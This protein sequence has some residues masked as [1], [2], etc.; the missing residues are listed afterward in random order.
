MTSP[1]N[2]A[3]DVFAELL[4]ASR[5]LHLEASRSRRIDDMLIG[6]SVAASRRAGRSLIGLNSDGVNHHLRFEDL[7]TQT[8]V[9][10]RLTHLSESLAAARVHGHVASTLVGYG[11]PAAVDAVKSLPPEATGAFAETAEPGV[12]SF[13]ADPAS[14]YVYAQIGLILALDRYVGADLRVDVDLFA[15]HLSSVVEGLRTVLRA[16]LPEA[17]PVRRRSGSHERE[18]LESRDEIVIGEVISA[19]MEA[20]RP[21]IGIES[22]VDY[23]RVQFLADREAPMHAVVVAIDRVRSTRGEACLNVEVEVRD[24]PSTLA[25]IIAR[26]AE[27]PALRS[28]PADVQVRREW[29][30]SFASTRV[31]FPLADLLASNAS[32]RREDR[33]IA[34][35][36]DDTIVQLK[37]LVAPMRDHEGNSSKP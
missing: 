34:R 23:H 5:E 30:S 22:D 24:E 35:L 2:E 6:A 31:R 26:H 11:E 7:A 19:M 33:S 25:G 36:L 12:V 8:R 28:P 29:N 17:Q 18:L 32:A 9:L 21:V 15:S 27:V 4:R 16:R 20:G 37:R 1:E 3:G 13:A 14:G 10:L